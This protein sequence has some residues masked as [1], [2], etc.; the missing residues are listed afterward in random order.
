MSSITLTVGIS[1]SG[2]STWCREQSELGKAT[3]SRDK[4]RELLFS[5][6]EK[7]AL[8]Y[9]QHPEHFH[10]EKA[11]TAFLF[12]CIR[13]ALA[14]GKDVVVD[15]THL[16][17]EFLDSYNVFKVP[18]FHKI[19]TTDFEDCVIRNNARNRVVPED[20]LSR[21]KQQFDSLIGTYEFRQLL[22]I[23]SN[24]LYPPCFI[25]DLDGTAA[26]RGNA[27]GVRSPFDWMRVAEDAP[28]TFVLDLVIWLQKMNYGKLIVCSGRDEICKDISMEWLK[29]FDVTTD[30]CYFRKHKDMRADWIV[31]EEM[32]REIAQDWNIAFLIDDRQQVVQHAR[33]L[34]L[35]VLDVAG[36]T[37]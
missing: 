16:K 26:L 25:L 2:K 10:R 12:R 23:H 21:Q 20:V 32:W 1:G 34:Q 5:Y 29:S 4:I 18:V 9:H 37:F 31:K 17:K 19:F 11:V 24:P 36:N 14:E 6:D 28:N 3:F 15:A 33:R 7:G 27:Q 8:E 13:E 22:P 30:I 35:N